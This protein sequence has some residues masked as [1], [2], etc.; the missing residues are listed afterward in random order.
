[1]SIE[2]TVRQRILVVEDQ[3]DV[4]S[5][6][7]KYLSAFGF[8]VYE[9][10]DGMDAKDL[11]SSESFDLVLSDVNMP[12]FNGLQLLVHVKE[13]S[14]ETQVILITGY[15]TVEMAVEAMKLG[16][17]IFLQKPI[18]LQAL[19]EQV[20]KALSRNLDGTVKSS[21]IAPK[22]EE[23]GL[24]GQLETSTEESTRELFRMA[25][26]TA[27][28]NSTVLITGEDGVGKSLMAQ[29][30]H[31]HSDR[32]DFPLVHV[33]CG[34]IPE[35]AL[36]I[37]LFGHVKG[38]VDS[39]GSARKGRL[40]MADKGTV[41]LAN[42][43]TLPLYIQAKLFKVIQFK[44][45]EPVGSDRSVRSDF[46]LIASTCADLEEEVAEGR[47]RKDLYYQLNVIP[48]D[49]PPLRERRNDLVLLI[50]Y[51]IQ[52][53]NQTKKCEIIGLTEAAKEHLLDYPWLGNLR[54]LEHLIERM[55]II[56]REGMLDLQHLPTEI[57]NYDPDEPDSCD[58]DMDGIPDGG[59]DF[60][61]AVSALEDNLIRIALQ[62]AE[63]NK[64]KAAQMLNLNRT[65][66]VEKIKKKGIRV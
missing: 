12:R 41:F 32:K 29:Y 5:V 10:T 31:Y 4:R 22:L 61:E 16:A 48:L 53:F 43:E 60:N 63:G 23:D 39:A 7:Q 20:E 51:F 11:L 9:A 3:P 52:Y 62:R 24:I 21:S 55:M 14:P 66:L 54:E 28:T 1:M 50:D 13:Q 40:K 57:Q 26:M 45:I 33:D 42:I 18:R 46:R 49:I 15:A 8:E 59:L 30:I 44:E 35:S 6:I 36:E 58:S 2:S 34:A 19:K 47:F 27:T 25:R 56:R 37:E 38:V 17:F 65:T 64:N